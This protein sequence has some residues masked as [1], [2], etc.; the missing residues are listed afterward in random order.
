MLASES[1]QPLLTLILAS[2]VVMGSP[3]PSTMSALAVS[4]AFGLRRSLV[5]VL[6]LM[7]GTGVVLVAVATGVV[8]VL[9]SQPALGRVLIYASAAYVLYLAWQIAVAPP[10]EDQ[11]ANLTSPSF[12]PGFALALANPK[13]WFAIAA[14]FTASTLVAG[15]SALD[16][17]LKVAV[18][19]VMII[20]IHLAWVFAG[21]SLSRFLRDPLISRIANVVFAVVLAATAIM[22]L[23]R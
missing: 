1:L 15:S 18:L 17:A 19:S 16:A 11:P 7:L 4:A 8:A 14:V 20:A 10:L 12:A 21:A 13:A 6:G 2:T 5:Y 22:P 9:L 3:G 23:L